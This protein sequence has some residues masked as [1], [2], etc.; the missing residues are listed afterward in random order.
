MAA[1]AHEEEQ[2]PT[3]W[4]GSGSTSSFSGPY[5]EMSLGKILLTEASIGVQMCV[6]A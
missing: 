4:K 1:V 6:N 3:I 5:V 2:S